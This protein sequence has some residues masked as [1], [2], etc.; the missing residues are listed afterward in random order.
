MDK[1]AAFARDTKIKAT[2]R[3]SELCAD[4]VRNGVQISH[5]FFRFIDGHQDW[6]CEEYPESYNIEG[7]FSYI[8]KQIDSKLD[9]IQKGLE[10]NRAI[11]LLGKN[12]EFLGGEGIVTKVL[13]QNTDFSLRP[14]VTINGKDFTLD[15]FF[16]IQIETEEAK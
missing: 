7:H 5:D 2:E 16:S 1:F 6:L 9:E 3:I 14:T 10:L 8:D 13:D 15:R 4:M 12:V 11:S